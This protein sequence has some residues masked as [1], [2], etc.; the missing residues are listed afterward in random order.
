MWASLCK[1]RISLKLCSIYQE[2]CKHSQCVKMKKIDLHRVWNTNKAQTPRNKNGKLS[3][4]C[5][6]VF[7]RLSRESPINV[8]YPRGKWSWGSEAQIRFSTCRD[9]HP[10]VSGVISASAWQLLDNPESVDNKSTA[11][12]RGNE[13]VANKQAKLILGLAWPW[14]WR[15]RTFAMQINRIIDLEVTNTSVI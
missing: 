4:V 10:P 12:R 6:C 7:E 15:R 5:C 3:R 13:S 2:S 8:K 11:E 9:S 1:E 14:T